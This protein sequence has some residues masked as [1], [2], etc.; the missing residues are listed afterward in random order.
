[1]EHISEPVG[2]VVKRALLLND[3]RLSV[4]FPPGH[5]VREPKHDGFFRS[6]EEASDYLDIDHSILLDALWKL[7]GTIN[8]LSVHGGRTGCGRARELLVEGAGM[9]GDLAGDM[10][11]LLAQKAEAELW[12]EVPHG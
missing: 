6:K 7:Q 8:L 12:C 10:E 3:V 9:V 1:M 2:R 11:M 4:L 5:R